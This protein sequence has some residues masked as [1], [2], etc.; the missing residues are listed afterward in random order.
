MT[1]GDMSWFA[2]AAAFPLAGWWRRRT[3]TRRRRDYDAE[4]GDKP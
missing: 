1:W 4:R 2:L 3:V